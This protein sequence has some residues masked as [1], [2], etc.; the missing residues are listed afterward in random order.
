VRENFNDRGCVFHRLVTAASDVRV[1]YILL[2][3]R[4]IQQ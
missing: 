2:L 1:R 4:F 3:V